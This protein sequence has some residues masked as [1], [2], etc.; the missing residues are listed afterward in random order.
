M[1]STN[2][3]IAYGVANNI[4]GKRIWNINVVEDNFF[5]Y[6]LKSLLSITEK[7]GHIMILIYQTISM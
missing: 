7:P 4:I 6:N 5:G 3:N 1:G 2:N